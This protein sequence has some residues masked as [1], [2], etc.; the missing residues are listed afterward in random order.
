MVGVYEKVIRLT[1][2]ELLHTA[3]LVRELQPRSLLQAQLKEEF[4]MIL[5]VLHTETLEAIQ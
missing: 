2:E 3:K 1:A 5:T 4:A